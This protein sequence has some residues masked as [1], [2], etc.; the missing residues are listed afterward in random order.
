VGVGLSIS[1]YLHAELNCAA[2]L[3]HVCNILIISVVIFFAKH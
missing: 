2:A 3:V 1:T